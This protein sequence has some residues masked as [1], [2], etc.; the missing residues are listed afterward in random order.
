MKTLGPSIGRD[1]QTH[2]LLTFLVPHTWYGQFVPSISV[3]IKHMDVVTFL[4]PLTWY[5]QF[6]PSI[7]VTIK[8][9]DLSHFWLP[10][11]GMDNLYHLLNLH[12]HKL[13][14]LNGY[15]FISS[16]NT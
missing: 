2:G 7:S 13:Y 1:H 8:H 16:A 10:T 12:I 15:Q 9:M 5:G 3:T 6:V 11:L 14:I 4:A